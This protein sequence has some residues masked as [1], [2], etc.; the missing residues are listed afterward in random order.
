[1]L[2]RR[3]AFVILF[4]LF[5]GCSSSS[6]ENRTKSVLGTAIT[7][8]KISYGNTAECAMIRSQCK[9]QYQQWVQNGEIACSCS[10]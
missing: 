2:W 6:F 10:K 1:M 3:C 9:G 5:A 4:S 7:G 8:N